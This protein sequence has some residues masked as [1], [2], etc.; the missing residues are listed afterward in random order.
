MATRRQ[1]RW[2][3]GIAL[4]AVTV[5]CIAFAFS[6]GEKV[7]CHEGKSLHEWFDSLGPPGMYTGEDEDVR[8]I[9]AIGSNAV[10]FLMRELCTTESPWGERF[11]KLWSKIGL[12]RR[13]YTPARYR[14]KKAY[15]C[16]LHLGSK[17]DL[18][19]PEVLNIAANERHPSCVLAIRLLGSIR[20][21]PAKVVQL[22]QKVIADPGVPGFVEA[23]DALSRQGTNAHPALPQMKEIQADTEIPICDRIFAARAAVLINPADLQ[24]LEFIVAQW[25][26]TNDLRGI[27]TSYLDLFG[28]NAM[29]A[30]SAMRKMAETESDASLP[31]SLSNS[32]HLLEAAF[33]SESSHLR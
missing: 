18:A 4:F 14:R 25:D 2:I 32:I 33:E 26:N 24:S 10:P 3:V 1:R 20:S 17:A 27:V 30:L 5:G 11:R 13:P 12:V 31:Y 21:D 8:A 7:P 15:Y 29:P 9:V 16:L 6:A 19:L 28:T 22:L 23:I